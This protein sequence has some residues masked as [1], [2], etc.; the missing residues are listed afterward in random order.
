MPSWP[1]PSYA[2][3]AALFDDAVTEVAIGALMTGQDINNP[4]DMKA[5]GDKLK[6]FKK[7]V[8][9]I[10]SS[11][12]EWN[13]AFAADAF[14]VSVYWSGAVA[15]SA[16][17]HKLP[18]EWVIPKEGAVGWLDNLCIPATSTKKDLGLSFINYMIDPKI[19]PRVGNEPRLPGLGEQCGDGRPA[20]RRS[21]PQDP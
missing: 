2:G 17:V 5:I 12:D 16:N 9:L 11:E 1:I 7:D 13:K 8:K 10:W 18:V 15:R 20:G 4:T 6:S 14:D 21:Q 3:R 19:L